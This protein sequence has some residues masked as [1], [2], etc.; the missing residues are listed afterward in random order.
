MKSLAKIIPVFAILGWFAVGGC[1]GPSAMNQ[2]SANVK[3]LA[4]GEF[5]SEVT[6]S[7]NAVV[8]DFYATWCGPCRQL[9]PM[10]DRLAD[11]YAGKINFVKI[12]VDELPALA[13]SFQVQAIPTLIFFRDG[14]VADRIT[15]L[16]PE[17]DLK[18]KLEAFGS[19]K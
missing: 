7:T 1:G 6:R 18:A 8:A 4:P 2:S 12:N 9:S 10:L 13:Q 16:M 14:K 17:T 5:E 15:G 19:G 3:H 11:G